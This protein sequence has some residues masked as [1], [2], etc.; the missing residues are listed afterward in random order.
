MHVACRCLCPVHQDT[1]VDKDHQGFEP[2]VD[3]IVENRRAGE[4]N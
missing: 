4:I 3:R 1:L 2:S